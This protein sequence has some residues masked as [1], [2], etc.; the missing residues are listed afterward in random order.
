MP[1]NLLCWSIGRVDGRRARLVRTLGF[2][3]AATSCLLWATCFDPQRHLPDRRTSTPNLEGHEM[4]T[5]QQIDYQNSTGADYTWVETYL[6]PI[7]VPRS[8][9]TRS[10]TSAPARS[11]A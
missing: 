11:W 5:P 2:D 7:V 4:I 10:S 6:I 1:W 8:T 3:H 9:S